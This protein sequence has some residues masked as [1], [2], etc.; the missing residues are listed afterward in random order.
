[1][2]STLLHVHADRGLIDYD[3][4]VS[5]YWPEFAAGGKERVTVRQVMCHEAGLYAISDMLEHGREMLDWERIT[6]RIAAA[7]PRHA[8][9]TGHGYH[10]LTY[11]WLVGEIVRRVAGQKP[12]AESWRAS[13]PG[14]WASRASTAASP[15]TSSTAAPP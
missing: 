14:P 10:A 15:R 2:A 13:W 12:F 11:G 5:E 4:P 6:E 7:A 9:G 3:T 1:M 8:P